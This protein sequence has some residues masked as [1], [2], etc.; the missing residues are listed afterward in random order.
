[1][2]PK[3]TSISYG[4]PPTSG[5]LPHTKTGFSSAL[6]QAQKKL[7][8]I[9][10]IEKK[11]LTEIKLKLSDE[12]KSTFYIETNFH[13]LNV[14]KV[15]FKAMREQ[16]RSLGGNALGNIEAV[17]GGFLIIL[18]NGTIYFFNSSDRKLTFI[19]TL[20]AIQA[21]TSNIQGL[22]DSIVIRQNK[23]L[24]T[25]VSSQTYIDIRS[26]IPCFLTKVFIWEVLKSSQHSVKRGSTIF[27][28]DECVKESLAHAAGVGARLTHIE[29]R[30][31]VLLSLGEMN[32]K[33][34]QDSDYGNIIEIFL[35]DS[36][37]SKIFSRGYRNPAGLVDYK[38]NVYVANQGPRG[39]DTISLV[40]RDSN[41]GWP[42]QSFGTEYAFSGYP[43]TKN[44]EED[45]RYSQPDQV[46][47]P[48]LAFSD[49]NI[50]Q[51][52]RLDFWQ[53]QESDPDLLT[54]SLKAE[55]LVR[56]R[57]SPRFKKVIYCEQVYLGER[58]RSVSSDNQLILVLSDS[59]Y[60]FQIER[61]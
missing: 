42:N 61:Q 12:V 60:I 13:N 8:H 45:A 11:I 5:T 1:M 56:C 17:K 31:S 50:N 21:D 39:G 6:F 36:Y 9:Y 4:I 49:L 35:N 44:S 28:T 52:R 27:E 53:N 37:E 14:R 55:S 23:S 22:R 46:F 19:G 16:A 51:Y 47:V 24:I 25:M 43:I 26:E 30:N 34:A 18:R 29:E 32:E 3:V 58:L 54:T 48:T 57:T 15:L 59:G 40:Q 7:N 2:N 38:G 41:F 20:K 10:E 33:H